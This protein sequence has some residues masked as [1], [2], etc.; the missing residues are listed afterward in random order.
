VLNPGE[1]VVCTFVNILPVPVP[2]N[3]NWV[4]LIRTL[5]LLTT[6][7]YFRPERAQNLMGNFKH[8]QKRAL[9]P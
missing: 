6:G 8:C 9:T 7:W 2:V 4:L 5:M 3:N 1:H